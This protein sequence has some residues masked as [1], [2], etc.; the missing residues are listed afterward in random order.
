MHDVEERQLIKVIMEYDNGEKEY[1]EGNDTTKWQNA[2]NGACLTSSIIS[3]I[4]KA[5]KQ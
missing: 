2:L 1:I 4:C 5:D 3:L